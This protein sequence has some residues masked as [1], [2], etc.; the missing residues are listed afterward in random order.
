MANA[1]FRVVVIN[2]TGRPFETFR[3]I[4]AV[5]AASEMMMQAGRR[6]GRCSG[7]T[8]ARHTLTSDAMFGWWPIERNCFVFL[9]SPDWKTSAESKSLR[10]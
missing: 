2:A 6:R 5:V 3:G 7:S 4:S 1:C 8:F 9:C 10:V